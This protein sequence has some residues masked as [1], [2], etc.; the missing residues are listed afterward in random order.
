MTGRE[1]VSNSGLS[2]ILR[3]GTVLFAL[4]I[5]I[6]D[7]ITPVDITFPILYVVVLL[8]VAS[9]CKP[10]GVWLSFLG[11]ALLTVGGYVASPA[12]GSHFVGVFNTAIAIMA[13][14]LTAFLAV[15]YYAAATAIREQAELIDL[16][17]D[18]IFVLDMNHV[19]TFWNRSAGDFYGW[20]AAEAIGKTYAELGQTTSSAPIEDVMAELLRTGGWE[21]E[22][23]RRKR[24]GT[25]VILACRW[26]LKRDKLG[27][28]VGMLVTSNDVTARRQAQEKLQEAQEELA[29]LNRVMLVNELAA[30]IAHE[31]K[32]P[33][34][35]A[36]TSAAAAIRWLTRESPS[37][38]EATIAIEQIGRDCLRAGEIVNSVNALVTKQAPRKECLPLN[39]AILEVIAMVDGTLHREHVMLRT[40]LASDLPPVAADRVQFQQVVLN[41]ITNAA[42][43][44]KTDDHRDLT[45]SSGLDDD[46]QVF[47]EVRDSGPGLDPAHLHRLFDSFH[48]T[49]PGGTGMGLKIS[50][51]IVQAHGGRLWAEPNQPR[52]A[53]FRFTLPVHAKSSATAATPGGAGH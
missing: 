43:A 51:S 28:P 20:S 19:I 35:A 42:E 46:N 40:H 9:F 8:L 16:T 31:V 1:L 29:R 37:I 17:H 47:V 6:A 27:K 10:R 24:D 15:R 52:G 41:L 4:A 34:S 21:G 49:K 44:M 13:M 53:I 12:G 48:T 3:V 5:F 33:I 39:E 11:C 7:L 36:T 30:S 38:D 45:V 23:M 26:S 32:Q 2:R 50:R 22:V 25:L 14:A 18:P